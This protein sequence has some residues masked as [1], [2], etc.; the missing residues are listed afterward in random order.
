M[1]FVNLRQQPIKCYSKIFKAN[2]RF[3]KLVMGKKKKKKKQ[4]KNG[5]KEAKK[6]NHFCIKKNW[7]S[8]KGILGLLVLLDREDKNIWKNKGARQLTLY[9][10]E[11]WRNHVKG[12]RPT[13]SCIV[14]GESSNGY[15]QFRPLKEKE[16]RIKN[17]DRER[18]RSAHSQ[19][20]D[21]S[22]DFEKMFELV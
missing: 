9:Q 3:N 21:R 5:E 4:Q 11:R 17:K 7:N 14:E 19:Y 6:Y 12:Y 10:N 16:R 20:K 2:Y 13:I 1:V 8:S 18:L 22:I 15:C